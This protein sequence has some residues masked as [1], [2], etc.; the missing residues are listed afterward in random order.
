MTIIIDTPDGMAFF[1]LLQFEGR[2]KI[3]TST[4]MTFRGIPT[5]KAYNEVYGTKFGRK[6][7]ALEDCQ[8]RILEAK[9]LKA[10]AEITD[11]VLCLMADTGWN[12]GLDEDFNAARDVLI[13]SAIVTAIDPDLQEPVR[14]WF[15]QNGRKE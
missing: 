11:A 8:R 5:L 14:E 13:E 9:V 1:R 4:K 2:L 10:C 3:E 6:S 7:A 15:R 12:P